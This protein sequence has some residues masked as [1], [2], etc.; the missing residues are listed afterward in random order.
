MT[1]KQIWERLTRNQDTCI[2]FEEFEAQ[3]GE[4]AWQEY[5]RQ[6]ESVVGKVKNIYDRDV[7]GF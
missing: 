1:L 3:M 7:E 2:S 6:H 5:E 4:W